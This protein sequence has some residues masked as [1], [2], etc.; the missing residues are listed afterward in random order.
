GSWSICPTSK[1]FK[2]EWGSA[3]EH[4]TLGIQMAKALGSPV[5][6][7]ILGTG[8]DRK[9]PGGIEARMAD[10]VKVLKSCR[11]KAIDAGVKVAIENHAGDMQAWELAGLIEEA[12]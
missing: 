11:S 8:E 4:L 3:E 10:T 12:G 9:T 7:V 5:F 1:A 6:R 2:G